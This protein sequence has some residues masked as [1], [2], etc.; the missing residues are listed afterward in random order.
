MHLG[1]PCAS[2]HF[3]R[4]GQGNAG[5]VLRLPLGPPPGRPL[6]DPPRHRLREL[7]PADFVA[8][9]DL[10]PRP[11][12]RFPAQ[13]AHTPRS[14]ARRATTIRSS[15]GHAHRLLLVPPPGLTR[16]RSHPPHVAA[17]VPHRLRHLPQGL[18]HVVAPGHLRPRHDGVPVARRP[19]HAERA[20]RATSTACSRARPRACVGCHQTDFNNSKNPNHA[21]AGFST[22]CETCHKV[23]DADVAA[24]RD[25]QPRHD[26]V[27]A[28]GR[29]RHADVHDVP[30]RRRVQ[31]QVDAPAS[32]ATRPTSTTAKNPNHAAAGFSTACETC[33]KVSDTVVDPG[34]V[35]PRHDGVPAP[36]RPRDAAVRDV[37]RRRRVQGQAHARASPAT[38]P[39]STTARTPTTSRP[40]SP[41]PARP[42]TRSPTR[43]GSRRRFN[44]ATTAFPL[45]GAHATQTCT[46]CHGDDVF[47]GKST[48]CVSCH[49]T[50]YNNTKNPNHATAGFPTACE[51]CHKVSDTTW[52][53]AT[54]NHATTAFPLLGVHATQT[55]ATCHGD[56]VLQGHV[57]RLRLLPPDR[58]S[59]TPRTP[60][61]RRPASPPRARPATRSPTPTWQQAT[62]N[63]ATTTFPL[64][65]VHATQSCTTCHGDG[66]YK[67]TSTACVS[68]H[69]TDYQQRKNPNHVHGRLPDRLR[70]LPQG[71]RHDLEPGDVQPRHDGVPARSACTPRRR[72]TTCHVDGVYKGTSTACVSCH[73]TDYQQRQEPQPRRGRL[74][75]RVRDLPQGLR[76]RPGSRATFNHATTAFPLVGV[77]ATQTL[78]DVPRRRRATRASPPP[79]SPATRPTINNA[80][81]PTTSTAGFPT[82]CETCHKVSDA[83]LEPGDVQPRHD[84][85][86]ARSACTPRRAARRAT[87]TACSRASPRACVACHQTDYQQ[88][89]EPQPRRGRLP[90]RVRDLPQGAT[91]T[92]SQGVF[93]HARPRSRCSACT[94]RRRARPAT[95]T[96][97]TR[98]S[99][100]PASPATRPTTSNATNPN[101]VRGRLPDRLRDLP[102]G[103]ATRSWSQG[104]FNHARPP[105]R[106]SACTRR[107][108]ARACH[109]D[110]VYKGKST[111]CV[112]LPPSRTTSRRRTRTTPPR[113]FPTTCETCH[114]VS[115][116]SW[117]QGTFNHSATVFPLL[118]VHAT[119]TVRRVPRRRRLQGQVHRLRLAATSPTTTEPPTRTTRRPGSRRRARPATR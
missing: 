76:R 91:R 101:H 36:R 103:R 48:A 45:L 51:T 41:P 106:S 119:Q 65:G 112:S 69:Q 85:V 49:Q 15:P 2:C 109:V 118:G 23:S 70:D 21:A 12:D 100:P 89:Q 1:V 43:P 71:L 111:A 24:G 25:V 29:P 53:Q 17:G 88:R 55:C 58:L 52:S 56:G 34:D 37:P 27:P 7:P 105:S 117:D 30:R 33:H 39:T 116:T 47:T 104:V 26:R 99:P 19:R 87:A 22:A 32:P 74:P 9:R 63:H 50:D 96:A 108:R 40:A 82:A 110:G 6:P 31:G 94:P 72:C 35:Q 115:D 5:P 81:T 78:H 62:F 46:T 61:T 97:S 83:D 114:K 13:L 95:A 73:Q 20:R 90:D 59:T 93:N 60:T 11:G 92:W 44:H 66:V 67:G 113:G 57:H 98:A 102:Q 68:C 28:P 54:F 107:S 84:G 14:T 8:G 64:L 4:P 16:P 10:E 38:R 77:H 79:A 3:E 42:A 18:R 86:P 80:R 75:D